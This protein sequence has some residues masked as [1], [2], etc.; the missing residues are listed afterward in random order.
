MVNKENLAILTV[1]VVGL[2]S[3][4]LMIG[5]SGLTGASVTGLAANDVKVWDKV[6]NFLANNFGGFV[7]WEVKNQVVV[8][9]VLLT[10]ILFAVLY[11]IQ[12]SNDTLKE[13]GKN[14]NIVI[15]VSIAVLSTLLVPSELAVGIAAVYGIVFYGLMVV[16]LIAVGMFYLYDLTEEATRGMM[17]LRGIA[18]SAVF[19]ISGYMGGSFEMAKDYSLAGEAATNVAKIFSGVA[20]GFQIVMGISFF[21]AGYYFLMGLFP[22]ETRETLEA[23]GPVAGSMSFFTKKMDV[24]DDFKS[25]SKSSH[26][27]ALDAVSD[28]AADARTKIQ[29]ACAAATP[30]LTFPSGATATENAAADT[31]RDD[32]LGEL[33]GSA[34]VFVSVLD[35]QREL[36]KEIIDSGKLKGSKLSNFKALKSSLDRVR[37]QIRNTVNQMVTLLTSGNSLK[38]DEWTTLGALG[39]QAK[40]F[41]DNAIKL[42]NRMA[43]IK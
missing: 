6:G 40:G 9:K 41:Y 5:S 16:G 14:V 35:S 1:L 26:Y 20:D 4:G 39:K 11:G 29:A 22:E 18:W 43:K 17:F 42:V 30:T 31:V 23:E 19:V 33:H 12:R 21:I 28:K 25:K 37:N 7:N 36:A 2:F 10:I 8:L 34:D 15:A 32:I 13:L 27:R 3:V 24:L 38:P